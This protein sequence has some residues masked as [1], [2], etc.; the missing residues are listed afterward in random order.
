MK[1]LKAFK[2]TLPILLSYF[3]L[4]FSF[5]ILAIKSGINP[6]ITVL[7]SIF[8]YSGSLQF[9][10]VAMYQKFSLIDIFVT[11]FLFNFRQFFYSLT[12]LERY[13]NSFYKFFTLTDETL[14][15]LSHQK[16]DAEYDLYVSV[17][18]HCYWIFGTLCGIIFAN[19]TNFEL[20]GLDF[21]L[22]SL[23]III[24]L[25]NI[26]QKKKIYPFALGVFAYFIF[27]IINV[28]NILIFSI[29]FAFIIIFLRYKYA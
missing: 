27:Y 29:L 25:E 28:P 11:S 6:Y 26:L 3:T 4:S 21:I 12:F 23:F 9:L 8:I 14:A 15:I 17:L 1:F 7:M 18:N 10:L 13:K 22:L 16:P 2:D 20:K 19:N 5:G 24:L